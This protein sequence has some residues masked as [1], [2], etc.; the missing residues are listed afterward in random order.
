MSSYYK[1]IPRNF[2]ALAIITLVFLTI[3]I[4]VIPIY[5][6][7]RLEGTVSSGKLAFYNIERADLTNST[8]LRKKSQINLYMKVLVADFMNAGMK[9]TVRFLPTGDFTKKGPDILPNTLALPDGSPNSI[10]FIFGEYGNKT[11]VAGVP[12]P[13]VDLNLALVNGDTT[14]YPFDSYESL[15]HMTAGYVGDNSKKLPIG[16][17]VDTSLQNYDVKPELTIVNG[18]IR[19]FFI[20][21]RA[22]TTKLLALFLVIL[23]WLLSLVAL[24][25]AIDVKLRNRPV[26]APLLAM[27]AGLIFALPALRNAAPQVPQI[28]VTIDILGFFWNMLISG[29]AA[30]VMWASYITAYE[31]P[32]MQRKRLRR[33]YLENISH[34]G[35]DDSSFLSYDSLSTNNI[36]SVAPPPSNWSHGIRRQHRRRHPLPDHSEFMTPNE[37]RSNRLE[38]FIENDFSDDSDDEY[39]GSE[40]E[41]VNTSQ[42][43]RSE[44]SV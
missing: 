25:I 29:V 16:L 22:L 41:E 15:L 11:F 2:R 33:E 26:A 10:N 34:N 14:D 18:A 31:D 1:K 7:F 43:R 3:S 17:I 35:D 6:A 28:G 13:P 21:N 27:F 32:K 36:H 5:L 40:D 39:E 38:T 9:V 37:L 4:L 8:D 42:S 12:M 30:L 24:G 19:I 23:M 44:V 20:A